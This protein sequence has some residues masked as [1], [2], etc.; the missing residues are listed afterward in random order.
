MYI[1]VWRS[2]RLDIKRRN[3]SD[4][5]EFLARFSELCKGFYWIR[6][7]ASVHLQN[8]KRNEKYSPGLV[9]GFQWKFL[10]KS[11]LVPDLQ[12]ILRNLGNVNRTALKF[13]LLPVQKIRNQSQSRYFFI[14]VLAFVQCQKNAE[15]YMKMLSINAV[16]NNKNIIQLQVAVTQVW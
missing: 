7:V 2:E 3:Y 4:P 12:I 9:G 15:N 16:A 10:L 8:I 6:T 13:E 5:R 1:S 11:V 14:V